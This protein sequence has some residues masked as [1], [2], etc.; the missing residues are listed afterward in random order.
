MPIIDTH[1][2]YNLEPLY[3]GKVQFFKFEQNDPILKQNWQDHWQ[4][5]QQ[6]GVIKSIIAGSNYETSKK[7]I[8]IAKQDKNLYAAIGLHPGEI[9][10]EETSLS[11]EELAKL[12]TSNQKQIIAIGETGLDYFHLSRDQNYEFNQ[13]QQKRLFIQHIQLAYDLQLPLIV[14]CRGSASNYP[15]HEQAYWDCLEILK[16]YH[17]SD[18]SFVLHCISGPLEYIDQALII[19]AYIGVGGNVT[20]KNAN[21]IRE[22][23]KMTPDDQLLIETDAPFLPPQKFRGKV[24]EPWMI[25]ETGK[26]LAQEL[27]I[28][29]DQLLDNTRAVFGI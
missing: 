22:I 16:S 13:K 25:V 2:H 7:S 21:H 3:S 5:A 10:L 28:N 19:G 29:L 4:K 26:Y 24:C 6:E 17:R 9:D 8:D 11:F 23:I 18:K 1:V 27:E 15:D 20:Y 14:H 12:A